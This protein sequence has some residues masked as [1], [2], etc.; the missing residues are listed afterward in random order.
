MGTSSIKDSEVS[1]VD[2]AMTK[3]QMREFNKYHQSKPSENNTEMDFCLVDTL[4]FI[5]IYGIWE[6]GW[7][8]LALLSLGGFDCQLFDLGLYCKYQNN[9]CINEYVDRTTMNI[10][11]IL[12]IVVFSLSIYTILWVLMAK[13]CNFNQY[14]CCKYMHYSV[15][16]LGFVNIIL[17]FWL[18]ITCQF[19]YKDT[20]NIRDNCKDII[21]QRYHNHLSFANDGFHGL[22]VTSIVLASVLFGC[23]SIAA[24]SVCVTH[25]CCNDK[26]R[27]IA[28]LRD[29]PSGSLKC[30][31][32]S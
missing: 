1:F 2:Y 24:I 28:Y 11:R 9:E 17:I 15:R 3:R 5:N 13:C 21:D 22:N 23:V 8:L 6:S 7:A 30:H 10:F 31:V 29:H 4:A 25:S 26:N 19:M 32:S 14:C 16:I 12:T 20:R 27:D 18:F